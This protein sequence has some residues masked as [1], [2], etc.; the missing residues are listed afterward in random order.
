[1]YEILGVKTTVMMLQKPKQVQQNLSRK[2]Q[3]R[4]VTTE[5]SEVGGARP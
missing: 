1:M 5:A 3:G 4:T 2:C